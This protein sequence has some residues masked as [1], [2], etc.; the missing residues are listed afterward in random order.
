MRFRFNIDRGGT[1]TDVFC[2]TS[3]GGAIVL[4]LLSEDPDNYNDAPTEGIRRILHEYETTTG[5][6]YQKNEIINTS[7]IDFIRMGTTVATN[8]LL[9]RKGAPCALVT[10]K[11]FKDLQLIGNQSRPKIF[12]LAIQRPDALYSHVVEINERVLL[13]KDESTFPMSDRIMGSSQ[14]EI[15]IE[16]AIDTNEVSASLRGIY[17]M[18]IRSIAVCFLHSYA[19]QKHEEIVRDIAIQMGFSHISISSEIMPT[20]R[21]VPRGCTSC[22][23]AYLTPIIKQY[24]QSFSRGT[25]PIK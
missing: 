17:D 20:I 9:E 19:Y 5:V 8:A 16:K 21:A 15:F 3:E 10:T 22:V 13:V 2:Q 4:K 12:D 7:C 6:S 25:L 14:E 24:L 23:D 11:G 18:G 1:F